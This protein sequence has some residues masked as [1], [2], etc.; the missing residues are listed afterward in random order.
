[1]A[2]LM[3]PE[4]LEAENVTVISCIVSLQDP[5]Q[6]PIHWEIGPK[7][8]CPNLPEVADQVEIARRLVS[9]DVP[10]RIQ[11]LVSTG[12]SATPTA[13]DDA[14]VFIGRTVLDRYLIVRHVARGGMGEV[15]MARQHSGPRFIREVVVKR[16]RPEHLDSGRMVDMFVRE[17]RLASMI[18]HPNVV[19]V[20]DFGR[21]RDGYYLAM[22]YIRGW[23][24]ATVVKALRQEG[25]K[26]PET[27]ACRLVAQICA[28]LHAAHNAR[29]EYGAVR[30]IVHRDVSPSNVLVMASG[31]VKITDFGIAKMVL[32][33][34]QTDPDLVKGKLAYMAPEQ[35]EFETNVDRR[36]DIFAAGVVLLECL[37]LQRPF[38]EGSS[39]APAVVRAELE[40][41]RRETSG[42]LE[43][44]VYKALAEEPEARFQTAAEME[45]DL[46]QCISDRGEAFTSTAIV[47]FLEALRLPP[48]AGS[49]V[50]RPD[51]DHHG[52]TVSTRPGGVA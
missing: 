28:G 43:A 20:L 47:E 36:A 48:P 35:L 50:A 1:M 19:T 7:S 14:L 37:T 41:H 12:G 23:D 25:R 30:E 46:E 34:E 44:V 2:V 5:D 24:L 27:V 39:R 11:G 16:L 8:V 45:T 51:H 32:P 13:S 17:A 31:Q 22:E 33:H 26:M 38:A 40:T 10:E 18:S 15:F 49:R 9:R 4:E 52:I 42:R 21:E 29:D 6:T 3:S